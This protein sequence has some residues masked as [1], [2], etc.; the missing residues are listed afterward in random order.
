MA[1]PKHDI[2]PRS[3][4]RLAYVIDQGLISRYF[5]H[6]EAD[7]STSI[8]IVTKFA[9]VIWNSCELVIK[10]EIRNLD[11][12]STTRPISRIMD[13]LLELEA[14]HDKSLWDIDAILLHEESRISETQALLAEHDKDS[15][16]MQLQHIEGQMQQLE[17]EYLRTRTALQHMQ[18]EKAQLESSFQSKLR[19]LENLKVRPLNE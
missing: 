12:T 6:R 9:T 19:E 10:L 1:A 3:F 15:M 5:G 18:D 8:C 17:E 7:Y 14:A 11:I 2:C 16:S 4:Q 13:R